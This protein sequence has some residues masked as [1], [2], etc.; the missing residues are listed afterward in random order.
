[1]DSITFT[2]NGTSSVLSAD[3]Y[4]P[5]ELPPEKNY[6][7]GLTQLLTY[8]SFPNIDTGNNKFYVGK[9]VITIPTGIYEIDEITTFLRSKNINITVKRNTSTL[10]CTILCDQEINFEPEDSIAD[11]LGFNKKILEPNVE[12]QSDTI[13]HIFKMNSI[14]IECNITTN[15]Y[16]NNQRSRVIHEFYPDVDPGYKIMEIPKN[17]IYFPVTVENIDRLEISIKDQNNRL[18]NFRGE[19]VTLQLHLKS[20]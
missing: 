14:R 2:L 11:I 20:S 12:H 17:V 15:S 1:M 19:T 13:V 16:I 3:Y 9:E 7:L 4:P 5:I 10:K 8:Y 6:V 18:L